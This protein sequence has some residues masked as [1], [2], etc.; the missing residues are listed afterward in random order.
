MTSDKT[1][2]EIEAEFLIVDWIT[3]ELF[4]E[5]YHSAPS[6]AQSASDC[7]TQSQADRLREFEVKNNFAIPVGQKFANYRQLD[8][9]ITKFL[10]AWRIVRHREV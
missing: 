5:L 3:P 6:L 7:N 8:L 1:H 2:K 9:Y 10:H 4:E